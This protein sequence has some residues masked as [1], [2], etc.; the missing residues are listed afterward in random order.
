MRTPTSSED[1]TTE[2]S[3]SDLAPG[4]YEVTVTDGD[5][6]SE[7]ES[8]VVD[9]AVPI[10][11][12]A[13]V[14][15]ASCFGDDDGEAQLFAFGG[16][17]E[18]QFSD[19]GVNFGSTSV[20]GGISSG[21]YAFFVQDENG[22]VESVE[23]TIGEPDAIVVTAIVSEGALDGEGSIDLTVT[24]GT[25]PYAYEWIGPSVSG[26]SGQDLEGIST[27]QYTVEVTDGAGCATVETFSITTSSLGCTDSSACN[28]EP[29][30]SIDDGSCDFSCYGCT[31]PEAF[32]FVPEATIDDGSCYFFIPECASIG[33]EGW[34]SFAT[35]V[36]P[37]GL[38]EREFG[39]PTTLEMVLHL[40]SVIE[41]PASGQT[42]VVSSFEPEQVIGLPLGLALDG[43]IVPMEANE[44]QCVEFL[45]VP[46]QEGVFEVEVVG[47]LTILLFGTPYLIGS[48]SFT[49]TLVITPNVNGIPGCRYAFAS[50]YNAIATYDDGSC[51]IAGCQDPSACNF[52]PSASQDSGQ[53]DYACLGCTYSEADNYDLSATQDNGT[54]NFSSYYGQCMFDAN[55]DQYVGSEDLLDF[56][57]MFGTS[58]E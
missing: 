36:Y 14:S 26:Q 28:Y 24:G 47:D 15:D 18:F 53:C 16:T 35:G 25:P 56:L 6:C 8:V 20:F 55:G 50:N 13:E 58:C 43:S 48:Y 11:V 3:V 23:V 37:E 49:Q 29:N 54:C 5:G 9:A 19:D 1:S 22:C 33:E 46:S 21:S 31:D 34:S 42:F 38:V 41:E 32:N 12:V 7:T 52:N 44:Q 51:F 2:T 39:I 45:G 17:E 30:A 10:E 40:A 27:G 4:T 57:T